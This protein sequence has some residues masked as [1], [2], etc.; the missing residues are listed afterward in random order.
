M[1]SPSCNP[2]ANAV[3]YSSCQALSVA[4]DTLYGI[5]QKIKE[6]WAL[7]ALSA[8]GA[9]I[10][11]YASYAFEGQSMIRAA[12]GETDPEIS[13]TKKPLYAISGQIFY[14]L[15]N[16]TAVLA[17]RYFLLT[18]MQDQYTFELSTTCFWS[19]LSIDMFIKQ[20]F[21]MSNESYEAHEIIA[22]KSGYEKPFYACMYRPLANK[23][24]REIFSFIG[25]LEHVLVDD[26]LGILLL[27][28]KKAIEFI[29]THLIAKIVTAIVSLA[30]GIPLTGILLMQAFLF[31]GGHTRQH[32]AKLINK[33]DTF[34]ENTKLTPCR[35]K[36]LKLA[37]NIMAPLHGIASAISVYFALST[38]GLPLS[39]SLASIVLIGVSKGVYDSEVREAKAEIEKMAEQSAPLLGGEDSLTNAGTFTQ[40]ETKETAI[41]SDGTV[42]LK[43]TTMQ[44]V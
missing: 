9:C 31:E 17:N 43:Q 2:Y 38:Y 19:I 36:S 33:E 21:A 11:F 30:V 26:L 32:L 40:A 41:N 8:L 24:A 34:T 10:E 37:S 25:S 6:S 14:F 15:C 18:A 22:N 27:L 13:A 16:M 12:S 1:T 5:R 7:G 29:K 39:L 35:A 23:R 28:P 44:H 42:V 3:L 4:C 20:A